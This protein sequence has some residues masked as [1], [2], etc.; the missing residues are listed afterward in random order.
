VPWRER[1]S[2]VKNSILGLLAPVIILGGLYTGVFTPTEAGAVA[3]VYSLIAVLASRQLKLKD[4]M[5]MLANSCKS[6]GMVLMIVVGAFLLG[7]FVTRLNIPTILCNMV[8]EA[9]VSRWAVLVAVMIMWLILGMFLEVASIILITVPII[10]PMVLALGFNGVW[11]GIIATL[12]FELALITPPVGLNLFVLKGVSEDTLGNV[13]RGAWP[14]FILM[15]L[16]IALI[17]FFPQLALW[18][19]STMGFI[20]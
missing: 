5:P 2:A 16:G 12:N 13:I 4:L 6:A 1:F 20:R 15:A 3:V 17:I 11:F 18:L 9:G 7:D 14:F 19:P 8:M 10:Y